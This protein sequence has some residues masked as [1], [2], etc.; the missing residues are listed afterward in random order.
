MGADQLGP[1]DADLAH[2]HA[3][4]PLGAALDGD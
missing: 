4:H 1:L 2:V 3:D